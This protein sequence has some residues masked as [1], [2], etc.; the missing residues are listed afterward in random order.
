MKSFGELVRHLSNKFFP[1][2]PVP[3]SY[4][5]SVC[6]I[7]VALI[8]GQIIRPCAHKDAGVAANISAT[9][10]GLGSAQ[11]AKILGP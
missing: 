11:A 1:G 6:G 7:A 8:G 5:C 9:A 3:V 4:E 10:Y 2:R